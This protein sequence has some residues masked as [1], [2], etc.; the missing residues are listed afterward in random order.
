[1]VD[2]ERRILILEDTES[3]IML[4]EH[5]LRRAGLAFSFAAVATREDF[6]KSLE[7]FRP[8]IILADYALPSYDGLSALEEA[9][10]RLPEVPFIFVS[11]AMGED[12]AAESLKCGADGYIAKDRLSTLAPAVLQVLRS[13]EERWWRKGRGRTTGEPEKAAREEM[14]TGRPLVLI[15]DDDPNLRKTLSDILRTKG[16]DVV[17][18]KD[19]AE[20]IGLLQER[21]VDIALIDLRLPDMS[22]IEV[23]AEV[24]K[25]SPSTDAIILTGNATLDSAIEAT[26]RG[27]FSYLQK[28]YDIDQLLLHLKRAMEKRASEEEIIRQ[29]SEL[30]RTNSEL[31]A[32]YDISLA[33]SQTIEMEKLFPEI[34]KTLTGMEMLRIEG[35]GA[36]FLVEG[37]MLCLISHVGLSEKDLEVCSTIRTGDCLCG[38]AAATGEIIIS[39]DSLADMR[40]TKKRPDMA[41][42]GHIVVPLKSASGVEGVLCLYTSHGSRI[43]IKVLHM[44][45][46]VGSQLGIAI[47]N[48]KLY[49]E[50]KSSSL[51]D[52]LTGL[53]NRRLLEIVF[54]KSVARAARSGKPLSVVMI[55]IDHFKDYNDTFGHVAG[56]K[57][58]SELARIIASKTREADLA[59]RYG[60][61]EFL[62]LLHETGSEGARTVA[63]TLRKTV[64]QELGI[65]ISLGVAVMS[66]TFTTTKEDFISRADEALYRAK[67]KGRNRVEV[68]GVESVRARGR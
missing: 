15:I 59:V 51:H 65:T 12:L 1:M 3:D 50:A 66:G 61:E 23:L 18:A 47:A 38:L 36:I 52:A 13:A 49:E 41:P 60:G 43:N 67:Q 56:D 42:H 46:S 28:P 7:D 44:L 57:I 45:S 34:L 10:K 11:G 55:D 31:Q 53:A 19:G 2:R 62:L 16:Y 30:Q 17:S 9:R 68:S 64:E 32:L 25:R 29:S 14:K 4:I 54:H 20:G 26:N 35:K 6:L 33:I 40:H 39:K 27:A 58:L 21:P 63:E 8:D 48:S 22:G 37:D 5:E 24:K